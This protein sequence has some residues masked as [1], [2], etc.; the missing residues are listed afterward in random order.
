[1]TRRRHSTARSRF[2]PAGWIVPAALAK[3]R[4]GGTLAINAVHMSPVPEMPY[5]T[6]YHERTVRSVANCTRD[7]A[8][9]LLALAAEIPIRSD[10][11][12]FPLSDANAALQRLKRSEIRGAAVLACAEP[13]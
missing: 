6:L 8:R 12:V 7:D 13:S 5:E 11:E 3:L 4:R 1:M 9:D 10:V 2:A